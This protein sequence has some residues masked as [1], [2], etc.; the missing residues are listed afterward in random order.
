MKYLLILTL[1][2]FVSCSRDFR[3]DPFTVSKIENGNTLILQNGYKVTLLGVS[4]TSDGEKYLHETV[5]KRN[6]RF[7]FD[8]SAPKIR[9]SRTDKKKQLFAYVKFGGNRGVCL[10]SEL[11]RSG[12]ATF[13]GHPFLVDSLNQYMAYSNVTPRRTEP[14]DVPENKRD[15]KAVYVPDYKPGNSF[16][17]RQYWSTDCT[18]NCKILETVC[19]VTN[20]YTRDFAVKLA[21]KSPGNYN[22]GQVCEIFD[23]LY[24]QWKYV[25]D[26]VGSE[27]IAKASESIAGTKL[28]GDCDD[29]AV[30]M[31]SVITAIG[32]K[33]RM[34][35]A[36]NGSSGHAFTEVEISNFNANDLQREIKKRFLQYEIRDLQTTEDRTGN[37]LN[38]DWSAAYPGG[39]YFE[40]TRRQGYI[41]NGSW[42]CMQN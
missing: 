30:V 11:L 20:N 18:D 1:L 3:K 33:A 10:N 2:F 4:N 25:N 15:D 34:N 8:K 19:D 27:Y 12:K 40:Y 38:M 35:C 26:P 21:S 24:N 36:W 14:S 23:Y 5:L 28:S 17:V 7:R 32:G 37:W 22:I 16:T 39:K 41:Y 9:L 42:E 6:V 13:E 29:Y 31:F